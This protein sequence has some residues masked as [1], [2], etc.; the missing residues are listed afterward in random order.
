MLPNSHHLCR[1][2]YCG[3]AG[4]TPADPPTARRGGPTGGFRSPRGPA[5]RRSF[6]LGL[7]ECGGDPRRPPLPLAAGAHCVGLPLAAGA[8]CAALVRIPAGSK[9]RQRIGNL[10]LI[11]AFLTSEGKWAE[12]HK[13]GITVG[14]APLSEYHYH[15]SRLPSVQTMAADYLE[16]ASEERE[17]MCV[18]PC[19]AIAGSCSRSHP[20]AKHWYSASG[21]LYFIQ[22]YLQEYEIT[23][24]NKRKLEGVFPAASRDFISREGLLPAHIHAPSSPK[25]HALRVAKHRI[26]LPDHLLELPI[27]NIWNKRE[28]L[29]S[30]AVDPTSRH[31]YRD[32]F[33]R[34]MR[35]MQTTCGNTP[36]NRCDCRTE[37]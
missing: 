8:R 28:V 33:E 34:S 36:L 25:L 31:L 11:L 35:E 32:R 2:R 1:C 17:P 24:G 27:D 7:R 18:V 23:H 16:D 13:S 29:N 3:S 30:R 26:H 5:A 14:L 12:S 37:A 10:N 15:K 22:S 4:E 9:G 20:H 19:L 6:D 21:I